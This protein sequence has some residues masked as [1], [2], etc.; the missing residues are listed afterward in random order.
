[1]I[2]VRDLTKRYGAV[3]ALRGVTFSVDRG[4]VI[5]LLGPN[6][7]GK[8]TAMRIITGYLA[9]TSGSARVD[10]QEVIDDP[11]ACQRKIGYLPEG[12]PLYLVLRLDEALKFSA[13]MHGLRGSDRRE[14]I[15][16]A[17][18]A[19]GLQGMERRTVATFSKGFRQR[20]GLAQALLHRPQILILDEPTSGLDPNQVED[21]RS[22]IR[23]LG[24]ER[25][26]ILSTHILPEVEA[27]CSGALIISNGK[28]VA[29][30][31]VDEIKTQAAGGV[32]VL[33]T[34]RADIDVARRAFGSVPSV[35]S[36]DVF[37]STEHPD[38]V[39]VHVRV[40]E[41]PDTALMEAVASAAFENK[42]PLSSLRTRRASLE[43]IFAKLTDE[44]DIE[45]L[46]PDMHDT[47]AEA[48]VESASAED[49]Q[50]GAGDVQ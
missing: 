30:G 11:I 8:S 36:L 26:V 35:A 24:E 23:S 7:A 1:M 9:P 18:E 46:G 33:A 2:E 13:A 48:L 50:E 28:L 16:A 10:G 39:D 43:Q 38:L 25:T 41:A 40:T 27:V 44:S 20:V 3:E 12:N 6:G 31:S 32:T 21:M 5:G 14:A 15:G 34:V 19:A 49:A 22:L 47:P 29:E 45:E 17:V 42:L 37:P 4:Q